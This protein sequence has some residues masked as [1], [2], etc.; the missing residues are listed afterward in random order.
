MQSVTATCGRNS[1]SRRT[2]KFNGRYLSGA[3]G[4]EPDL[5]S[6]TAAGES[7]SL[8]FFGNARRDRVRQVDGPFERRH[9]EAEKS[10][11][12]CHE[13][14]FRRVRRKHAQGNDQSELL[15]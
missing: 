3:T 12:V 13:G 10:S 8:S 9:S 2:S 15:R 7:P 6:P 11:T 14:E 5:D 4:L 1:F